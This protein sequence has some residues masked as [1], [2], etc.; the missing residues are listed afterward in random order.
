VQNAVET[1]MRK[2]FAAV[3]LLICS[4]TFMN[5]A[6]YG[7]LK[8]RDKP[9]VFMILASWGIAF[10]EYC[11]QVPANRIGS[12]ALTVTQ[13]KVIQEGISLS[14]FAV[15]AFFAFNEKPTTNHLIAFVLLGAACYFATKK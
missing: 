3:G 6:W 15:F 8:F 7:H 5:V 2:V 4:N 9:L 13:L 11:F 1:R 10:F 14:T 12:E